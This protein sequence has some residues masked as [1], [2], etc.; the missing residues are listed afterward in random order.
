[1]RGCGSRRG[2]P[3]AGYIFEDAGIDDQSLARDRPL[4]GQSVAVGMRGQRVRT[5]PAAI[6]DEECVARSQAKISGLRGARRRCAVPGA[7]P[8][9]D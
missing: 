8:T 6:R 2:A 9:G 3:R 7:P 4:E 1:M 5:D